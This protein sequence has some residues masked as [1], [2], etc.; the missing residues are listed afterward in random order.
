MLKTGIRIILSGILILSAIPLAAQE[1]ITHKVTKGQ[2]LFSISKIYHVSEDDIIRA[3]PGSESVIKVGQELRIPVGNS[4]APTAHIIRTGET[5]YSLAKSNGLTVDE[6][7]KANPGIDPGKFKA[8]NTII[9]P[10]A[11]S[12]EPDQSLKSEDSTSSGTEQTQT[13]PSGRTVE[14]PAA[15]P[16]ASPMA[17]PADDSR[18][19]AITH[20]VQK[21]ETVYRICREYGISTNEFYEA[22]PTYKDKKL[23]AGDIVVIPGTTAA[24]EET[25]SPAG[26]TVPAEQPGPAVVPV[27]PDTSGTSEPQS[28]VLS[29]GQQPFTERSNAINAAL[30]MPFE[31][32]RPQSAEQKK[33]VEFYQGVLLTLEDMKQSGISVN[34]K[35]YDSGDEH[36]SIIPILNR[37]EM[38]SMDVI[39]GPKYDSHIAAAAD[40]AKEHAIPLVL[41]VSTQSEAVTDNP[42]IFQLNSSHSSMTDEVCDHFFRQFNRAR[43][44]EIGTGSSSSNQLIA[45]LRERL[46]TDPDRYA[47]ISLN[48]ESEDIASEFTSL[49]MPGYQNIFMTSATGGNELSA[50]LPILQLVTRSKDQSI[51]THLFG[52]PEYQ[53]FS[54]NYIE[55]FY[56]IDTW[57]YTWFYTNTKLSESASFG[58]RFHKAFGRQ[59][60]QTYPSYAEYGYDMAKFF[61]SGISKYGSQFI[62]NLDRISTSPIQM[63]FKFRRTDGNGGFVNRKV[64]FVHM[65]DRNVIQ[66]IDFD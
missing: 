66:K 36:S 11:N 18:R 7:M 47:Y 56:E 32:D 21:R 61:L 16:M 46:G 35:V 39:F 9:I 51:E 4:N 38:A 60:L 28:S 25:A 62:W 3:N 29:V 63:G 6:L 10:K 26:Q 13:Q 8:G 48:T 33:M 17:S 20:Q 53:V 55:Q 52:Y 34:L 58:I 44:I 43:I 22:N 59:L 12:Q 40:F 65:S 15:Q 49:L 41:P 27:I 37:S 57:F 24:T 45:K 64:F 1:Y 54:Q 14:T 30:I 31:L 23:R 2:G 50:I 19:E 5:L 42:Y